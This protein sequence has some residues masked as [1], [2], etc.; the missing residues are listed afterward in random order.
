MLVST[1]AF[2]PLG[3]SLGAVAPIIPAST[4]ATAAL[5]VPGPGPSPAAP[6]PPA[7]KP[8]G[9]TAGTSI[10]AGSST[11]QPGLE[12]SSASQQG[13]VTSAVPT[14]VRGS[15]V[16]GVSDHGGHA[17]VTAV[18]PGIG[19]STPAAPATTVTPQ[20]SL[21][22][23][24]QP[25]PHT[26]AGNAFPIQSTFSR[27]S[28]QES[29]HQHVAVAQAASHEDEPTSPPMS[30]VQ[31]VT[32]SP[33]VPCNAPVELQQQVPLQSTSVVL[34]PVPTVRTSQVSAAARAAQPST[35]QG[36]TAAA[37][38]AVGDGVSTPTKEQQQ[39]EAG[40]RHSRAGSGWVMHHGCCCN[41]TRLF[42]CLDSCKSSGHIT[43]L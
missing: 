34:M 24:M 9:V 30:P 42:S 5:G 36:A 27:P 12:A 18:S 41:S 38:T 2:R 29:Q 32:S 16:A 43:V 40:G 33:P 10:P 8:A 17:H 26:P 1:G 39:G 13:P 35:Q 23:P 7:A 22:Q 21:P 19:N 3:R 15:E 20:Q 31:G 25:L 11:V 14:S 6:L 37:A 4:A 28:P